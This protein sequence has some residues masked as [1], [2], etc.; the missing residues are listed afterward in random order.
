MITVKKKIYKSVVDTISEKSKKSGKNKI[1]NIFLDRGGVK[2]PA[3]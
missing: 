1:I 2:A 3:A